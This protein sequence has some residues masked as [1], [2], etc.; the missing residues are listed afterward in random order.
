MIDLSTYT[1]EGDKENSTFFNEYLPR[2][3]AR[4]DAAGLTQIVGRMAAA[5]IQVEHGDAINY[6][7]ELAVMG[8]YRLVEARLSDTAPGVPA[9]LEPGVP[10]PDR[11]RAA[12]TRLRGRNHP[13]E[14]A[15]PAV[16][17][18]AK[19]ALRRR[20]LQRRL[21]QGRARGSG[22]AQYP[23]RGSRRHPERRST[24]ATTSR[25]RSSP[26][27]PTTGSATPTST[28]TTPKLWDSVS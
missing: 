6:L 22:A 28:S 12:G 23:V 20:D 19:R 11:A 25:S 5:V 18:Q 7:A 16:E 3:Y 24:A 1:P 15:V 26:T 10:P 2:V 4:R 13:L 21:D 14:H 27:S 17:P 9:A 8:P